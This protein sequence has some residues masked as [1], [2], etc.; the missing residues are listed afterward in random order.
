LNEPTITQPV[1]FPDLFEKPRHAVFD[2]PHASSDG[3]AVLLKA[4]EQPYGLIDGMAACL[5]DGRQAGKVR[6]SVG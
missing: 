5:R 3:G 1:I 2:R 4:A 6:H